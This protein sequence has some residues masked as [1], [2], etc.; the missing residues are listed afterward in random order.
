MIPG[1][2]G[3]AG[4]MEQSHEKPYS[5]MDN[6]TSITSSVILQGRVGPRV[7]AHCLKVLSVLRMCLNIEQKSHLQV[8][9]EL[10]YVFV[11]SSWNFKWENIE[12]FALLSI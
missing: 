8:I 2:A 5:I 10:V 1:D 12:S 7:L 4:E 11:T 9:I 3:R 6:Q